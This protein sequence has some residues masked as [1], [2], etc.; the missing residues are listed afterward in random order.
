MPLD[1]AQIYE[2]PLL[3]GNE[4]IVLRGRS[5]DVRGAVPGDPCN[6]VF[7]RT[8]HRGDMDAVV[9]RTVTWLV[10]PATRELIAFNRQRYGLERV[11]GIKVGEPVRVRYRND[12]RLIHQIRL[13]D[14]EGCEF[15]PGEFALMPP[16]LPTPVIHSRP[17]GPS[18][19]YGRLPRR[20]PQQAR[21]KAARGARP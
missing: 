1:M 11:S 9:L 20:E 16:D 12:D 4:V 18:R 5:A 15:V 8:C 14:D 7:A 2:L 3:D 10:G 17:S 19:G 6:C 13:W 21:I